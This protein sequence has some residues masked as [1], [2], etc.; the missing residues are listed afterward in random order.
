MLAFAQQFGGGNAPVNQQQPAQLTPTILRRMDGMG[1][2]DSN[3]SM[4][5]TSLLDS[6]AVPFDPNHITQSVILDMTS[7]SADLS[8]TGRDMMRRGDAL[9]GRSRSRSQDRAENVQHPSKSTE[10]EG[11]SGG[12]EDDEP[13]QSSAQ[14]KYITVVVGEDDEGN[15]VTK[16]MLDPN[17]TLSLGSPHKSRSQKKK[18]K[19]R[20]KREAAQ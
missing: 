1:L 20:E 12:D 19:R 15:Q 11:E 8:R 6:S 18:D 7:S 17:V 2:G 9:P 13:S 14:K 10:T 5:Q 16:R 4:N 3:V